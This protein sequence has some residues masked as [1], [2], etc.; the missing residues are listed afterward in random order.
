MNTRRPWSLRCRSPSYELA[1]WQK[2][3]CAL[4]TTDDTS[5]TGRSSARPSPGTKRFSTLPRLQEARTRRTEFT[6][7]VSTYLKFSSDKHSWDH[8]C[9]TER[10][11][12]A[13]LHV[14]VW[15]WVRACARY[16][17]GAPLHSR[18]RAVSSAVSLFFFLSACML[19]IRRRRP[20]LR[21]PTA[22]LRH[23]TPFSLFRLSV[24]YITTNCTSVV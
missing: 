7:E 18:R 9:N 24:H 14:W 15:V 16:I 20:S 6:G 2:R 21:G 8:G 4:T 23:L 19:R 17:L 22:L 10:I 11:L 3:G 5:S 1:M 13:C 12:C